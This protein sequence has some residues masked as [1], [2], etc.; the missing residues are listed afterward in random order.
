MSCV[1]GLNAI[2][3]SLYDLFVVNDHAV[4][5]QVDN[6]LYYKKS[7]P[8]TPLLIANMLKNMGSIGCYQQCYRTDRLRWLCFDFD[9]KDKEVSDIDGLYRECVHPITMYLDKLGI[10]YLTEFS[11]RRGIHI[12]IIFDM[13]TSK[14]V[15]YHLLNAILSSVPELRGIENSDS[16]SLD[17]FPKTDDAR[18][19]IV[20]SQVKLPLSTHRNGGRSFFF[21]GYFIPKNDVESDEFYI[22]QLSILSTYKEQ[23]LKR[24]CEI[25][26]ISEMPEQLLL[27]NRITAYNEI[28]NLD[29]SL[30]EI[31][32]CL[33]ETKVYRHIFERMRLGRAQQYDWLVLLGTFAPFDNDG[34]YLTMVFSRY[35]NYDTEKT[36]RNIKKLKDRYYP[37]K[38]RYLYDIYHLD[39]ESGLNPEDTG[40]DYIC[41]RLHGTA[42]KQKWETYRSTKNQELELQEI[43]I[44]ERNYLWDNDEVPSITIANNMRQ[45]K[46]I[47]LS[48]YEEIMNRYDPILPTYISYTRYEENKE[49]ELISLWPR[50]RL[51]TTAM[52]LRLYDKLDK[53]WNSYSYQVS[54]MNRDYIFYPWYSSWGRFISQIRVYLELPFM[55]DAYVFYVDLKQCYPHVDLLNVYR[56]IESQLDDDGKKIFLYLSEYNDR[57]MRDIQCGNRI[58]VPQGPA[59]ARILTEIY[60]DNVVKNICEDENENDFCMFR[61]VDDIVVV[62]D[63]EQLSRRLFEKFCVRLKE[64]GMPINPDKTRYY[65]RILDLTNSQKGELLHTDNFNYDLSSGED[66]VF[67]GEADMSDSLQRFMLRHPFDIGLLGYIYGSR[68]FKIAQHYYFYH[69]GRSIMSSRIGRGK[70]FRHFYEYLLSNSDRIGE[71]LK[72]NWFYEIPVDT[73]NYGNFIATLYYYIRDGRISDTDVNRI[74][75]M[76]LD[77]NID[78]SYM[79]KEDAVITQAILEWNSTKD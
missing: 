54:M 36:V 29:V 75:I 37:A 78:T 22:E 71:A 20:G 31:I 47:E 10:H 11:G 64:H 41:E 76:Y 53:S 28:K 21:E 62:S 17:C 6:G 48:R 51:I 66:D 68:T 77:N 24:I 55:Q 67:Y 70:S 26:G 43:L 52:A 44:K 74:V 27:D 50:D 60:L 8:V 15:A 65:G 79:S 23:D 7:I 38:F 33:E 73:V 46:R 25:F 56:T 49:R 1:D 69:Y 35:P 58:G 14:Y 63:E 32:K 57:L 19:N 61:Y 18:G 40:V 59:Y 72:R 3:K 13:I 12:W 39:L 34:T 30:H 4:A 9:C 45:M 42:I 16:W 5:I 2:A